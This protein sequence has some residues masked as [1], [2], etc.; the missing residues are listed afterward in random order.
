[1]QELEQMKKIKQY[2]TPKI[3]SNHGGKFKAYQHQIQNLTNNENYES[4]VNLKRKVS[5]EK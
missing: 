3:N 4:N 1:M 5:I 2:F